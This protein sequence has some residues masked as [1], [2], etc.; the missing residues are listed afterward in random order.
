MHWMGRWSDNIE[1]CI[2]NNVK[3]EKKQNV[4][5]GIIMFAVTWKKKKAKVER[6]KNRKKY[7][8]VLLVNM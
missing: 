8:E 1:K 4:S 6:N 7:S 2:S 5:L 3:L